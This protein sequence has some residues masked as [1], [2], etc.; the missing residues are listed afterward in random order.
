MGTQDRRRL[1]SPHR[2]REWLQVVH[3]GEAATEGV[4]NLAVRLVG[5]AV[6]VTKV[7]APAVAKEAKAGS[8]VRAAPAVTVAI[9]VAREAEEDRRA[10]GVAPAARVVLMAVKAD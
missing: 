8:V 4:A 6:V 2:H 9:W 10:T 7:A 3:T 5:M 1:R